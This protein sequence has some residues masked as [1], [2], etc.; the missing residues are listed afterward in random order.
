MV[1]VGRVYERDVNIKVVV[2]RGVI[3]VKIDV[4]GDGG[5]S[6]V[7][8]IIVKVDLCRKEILVIIFM[9]SMVLGSV[10]IYFICL[11]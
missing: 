4:K 3:K 7:F 8:L 5:L 9:V 6:W 2:V 1:E 11:F 10:K